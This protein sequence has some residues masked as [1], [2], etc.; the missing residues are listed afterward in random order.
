MRVPPGRADDFLRRP[1]ANVRAVLLY[2]VDEGL[3]RERAGTAVGSVLDDPADPFRLAQLA[4]GAIARDPAL[5]A[6]EVAAISMV[7]GRRVI[8]LRDAGDEIAAPL[9]AV[10]ESCPGD[11]LVVIEAGNLSPRSTLR[12]LCEGAENA[13][14]VACYA[15]TEGDLGRLVDEVLGGADIAIDREARDFLLANLGGDRQMSRRELEKLALYVG[16]GGQADLAAAAACVG[17]SSA[18][19]LDDLV[20]AVANGDTGGVVRYLQRN[21]DEGLAPVTVL[22]AMQRHL[23]RLHLVGGLCAAGRTMDDALRQLRPPVF[24]KQQQG[25]RQQAS[26]WSTR[27]LEDAMAQLTEAEIDSKSTGLPPHAVCER[28]LLRTAMTARRQQIAG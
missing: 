17:D 23:Q 6:D 3:V 22:R 11:A 28:A 24:W 1:D 14:A 8:R 7:G 20:H 13:A 4:A 26:R 21:W 2:G 10:L 25:F 12:K 15:D 9:K 19:T 16:V 27:R 18:L 5:L